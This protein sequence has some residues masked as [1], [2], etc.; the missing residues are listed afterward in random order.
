MEH[1][2]AVT[3]FK[4]SVNLQINKSAGHGVLSRLEDCNNSGYG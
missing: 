3:C 2:P 4:C 1:E